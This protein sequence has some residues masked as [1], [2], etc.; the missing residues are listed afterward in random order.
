MS[1]PINHQDDS[2]PDSSKP[3][4][5]SR[6]LKIRNWFIRIVVILALTTVVEQVAKHV[7][8][9]SLTELTKINHSFVKGI[10]EINPFRLAGLFYN[11]LVYGPPREPEPRSTLY[12]F[13]IP[14][15]RAEPP[16]SGGTLMMFWRIIPGAFHTA[17][18]VVFGGWIS[19]LTALVALF[20][21]F[22]CVWSNLKKGESIYVALLLLLAVPLIGSV[23]LWVLLAIV[24]LTGLLFG[25]LLVSAQTIAYFSVVGACVKAV[26]TEREH[27]VISKIIARL[28]G[29]H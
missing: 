15:P 27:D 6:G 10:G 11:Y 26:V 21:G 19:I 16:Q 22:A 14:R 7:S 18:T 29:Q 8:R 23:F 4:N 2:H 3:S 25:W 28:T 12:G 17:K 20:L 1:E 13:Q 5:N 9:D 24:W